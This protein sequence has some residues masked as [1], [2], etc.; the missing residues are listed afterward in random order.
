DSWLSFF[1]PRD[2]GILLLDAVLYVPGNEEA[3]Y[4]IK[5]SISDDVPSHACQTCPTSPGTGSPG[6]Q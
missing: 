3:Q 2:F 5:I 1:R 6:K 4:T